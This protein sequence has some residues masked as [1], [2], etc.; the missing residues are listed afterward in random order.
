VV[1]EAIGEDEFCGPDDCDI[2]YDDAYYIVEIP[3]EIYEAVE[4]EE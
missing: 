1:A 4:N 2:D 3:Y